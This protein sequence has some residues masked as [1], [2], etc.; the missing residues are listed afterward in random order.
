MSL[1]KSDNNT[2]KSSWFMRNGAFLRL[3]SVE[4]GYT[5]RDNKNNAF[6]DSIRVY[7]SGT[8]LFNICGFDLWDIEMGGDG[9]KYPIQRTYNIG[10]QFNF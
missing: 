4:L 9:F 1:E 2:R 8:N 3:K 10:L 6:F 5:F 7:L